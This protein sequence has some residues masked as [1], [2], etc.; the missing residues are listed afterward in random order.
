MATSMAAGAAVGAPAPAATTEALTIDGPTGSGVATVAQTASN[1]T[2]VG[3]AAPEPGTTATW[4][5][6]AE[7]ESTFNYR[8]G[9]TVSDPDAS[10]GSARRYSSADGTPTGNPVLFGGPEEPRT[11]GWYVVSFRMKVDDASVTGPVATIDFA[12]IEQPGSVDFRQVSNKRSLPGTAWNADGQYQTFSYPVYFP[13]DSGVNIQDRLKQFRVAWE[14]G[15]SLYID[16]IEV[17]SVDAD[18]AAVPSN[19][20]TFSSASAAQFGQRAGDQYLI[21]ATGVDTGQDPYIDEYSTIY[22]QDALAADGNVTVTVPYQEATHSNGF[23]KAGL[24]V[25]NDLTGVNASAGY[26]QVGVTAKNGFYL[27]GDTD[28]NGR[29]NANAFDSAGTTNMLDAPTASDQIPPGY[30]VTLRLERDGDTV[31]GYYSLDQGATFTQISTQTIPGTNDALDVGMF[32]LSHEDT[33]NGTVVFDGFA[34]D[35]AVAP[36]PRPTLTVTVDQS[37]IPENETA[38]ANLT[39]SS[40]PAGLAGYTLTVGA[41]DPSVVRTTAATFPDAFNL[42]KATFGPDN[43]T[44]TLQATDV[45]NRTVPGDTDI[46]LA[47]VE[48]TG[49]GGGSTTVSVQSIDLLDAED[50]SRI[51]ADVDGASV[52][53]TGTS[54]VVT[55]LSAPGN[56]SQGDPVTVDATVTNDGSAAGSETVSFRL[57]GET[58]ATQQ[59]ALGADETTQVSFTVQTTGLDIGTYTHGV[60][61]DGGNATAELTVRGAA[62][63]VVNLLAPS[64]VTEG[65]TVTV[66]STIANLGNANGSTTAT[67]SFDG[68]QVDST[69]VSLQGGDTTVVSFQLSTDGVTP[70]T[71]EHSVTAAGV[72]RSATITVESAGPPPLTANGSVPLDTDGD[73]RYE[74]VDGDGETSYEDVVVLFEQFDGDVVQSNGDAFDFNANGRVDFDDLVRLFVSI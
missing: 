34:V 18:Y 50:G 25:R 8:T 51:D 63:D 14:G 73:G 44:V 47:S 23:E 13:L 35:N 9:A 39:L 74:D 26:A 59:V 69:P 66:E 41:D 17:R 33:E 58:L 62:F 21:N 19:F 43:E 16:R 54:F 37:S 72:T 3:T 4:I 12:S 27:N 53:S 36:G 52:S 68:E 1:D 29:L 42:T 31:T 46:R 65:G 71:Y 32:G 70:G 24:V 6:E 15:T 48:L 20:S 7:N 38:T 49:D 56:V 57:D 55:G 45:E 10:G 22:Q 67:F 60:F 30:P 61:T 64:R 2:A 40:A 5:W 11:P 28:G